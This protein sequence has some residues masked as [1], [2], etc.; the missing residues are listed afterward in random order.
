MRTLVNFRSQPEAVARKADC[1][2]PVAVS[3]ATSL[4]KDL[5]KLKNHLRTDFVRFT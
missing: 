2:W 1:F 4:K 5:S 3:I